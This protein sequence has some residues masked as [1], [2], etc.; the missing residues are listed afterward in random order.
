MSSDKCGA[1]G[2]ITAYMIVGMA[3]LMKMHVNTSVRIDIAICRYY[4]LSVGIIQARN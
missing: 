1:L 3:D 4:G 2:R